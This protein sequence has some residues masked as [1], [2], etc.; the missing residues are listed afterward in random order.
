MRV[1]ISQTLY[2][3]ASSQDEGMSVTVGLNRKVKDNIRIMSE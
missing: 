2:L 1:W 3:E